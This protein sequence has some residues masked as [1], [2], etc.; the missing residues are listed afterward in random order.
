MADP[1]YT[2]MPLPARPVH[3]IPP[4]GRNARDSNSL[5]PASPQD[6]NMSVG[7]GIQLKGEISNCATL[8]VEGDVDATLD[9]KALEITKHGVFYGTARVESASIQGR[10]DGD[11]T[12]SGLLRVESGGS[13]SGELRYGQ[14]EV[15]VG[16]DLTGEISKNTDEEEKVAA[17]D[18]VEV[19]DE[20]EK[21]AADDSIEVTDKDE[22][23]AADNSVEVTDENS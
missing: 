17:D 9:G 3:D 23:S 11:L 19:T 20:D 18:S 10:F 5:A 4:L 1:N 7:P 2:L 15:A 21:S 8:I 13:A 22:M 14:L 6:G 16:G 12:V